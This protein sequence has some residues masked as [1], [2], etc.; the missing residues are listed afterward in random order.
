LF[1]E[2]EANYSE[3]KDFMPKKEFKLKKDAATVKDIT[4]F[5]NTREENYAESSVECC[6]NREKSPGSSLITETD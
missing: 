6:E 3:V 4:I 2:G 5:D 1:A